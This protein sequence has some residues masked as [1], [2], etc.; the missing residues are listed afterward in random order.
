MSEMGQSR[1][2]WDVRSKSVLHST[3]DIMARVKDPVSMDLT[4]AARNRNIRGSM[5]EIEAAAPGGAPAKQGRL[6]ARSPRFRCDARTPFASLTPTI[7]STPL[8]DIYSKMTS[9]GECSIAALF[10]RLLR[11]QD[12]LMRIS[13]GNNGRPVTASLMRRA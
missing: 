1:R 12:Q 11:R 4:G 3:S 2:F 9:R 7:P 6:C 8:D 5:T 10:S 13:S